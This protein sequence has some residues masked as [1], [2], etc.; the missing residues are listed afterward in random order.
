MYNKYKQPD[1]IKE[2]PD[3]IKKM[4]KGLTPQRKKFVVFYVDCSNGAMAARQ[5]KYSVKAAKE[6]GSFL[7]TIAN[8]RAVI[9]WISE[10]VTSNSIDSS[11]M[12]KIEIQQKLTRMARVT[13]D[14]ILNENGDIDIVKARA[15]GAIEALSE[16]TISTTEEGLAKIPVTTKK[17]KLHDPHKAMQELNKMQGNYEAEK[18]EIKVDYTKELT[19]DELKAELKE[20]GIIDEQST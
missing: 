17:I 18:K 5:A 12:T 16:L 8:I 13:H 14:D 3:D 11:I 10:Y 4:W 7:L 20:L 15:N 9:N 2:M 6:Q 19:D 1:Y